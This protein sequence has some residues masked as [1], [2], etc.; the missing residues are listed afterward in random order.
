MLH[1]PTVGRGKHIAV[2]DLMSGNVGCA[3]MV[4]SGSHARV[5]AY[6]RST[7][8]LEDRDEAHARSRLAEEI[9]EATKAALTLAPGIRVSDV[10]AIV[11]GPWTSSCTFSGRTT[12]ES[13]TI[14]KETHISALAREA[15]KS[16]GAQSRDLLEARAISIRLNGYATRLPEG[17]RAREIE[18][19][20]LASTI[21]PA[22]KGVAASAISSALPAASLS[23]RSGM[24]AHAAM[25]P[26][27]TVLDALVI[28]VGVSVTTITV[29]KDGVPAGIRVITEGL[30][31]ILARAG[32][33]RPPQ[34]SL[35]RMRM[36]SRDA[37]ADDAS[38][39]LQTALSAA[40]PELVKIFGESFGSLAEL[41]RLP[42][43]VLLL[44]HPDASPY[45]IHFFER[46]DFSQFT[47][48]ASAFSVL[49][50]DNE[51]LRAWIDV[52]QAMDPQLAL[53]AS[54]A[55]LE[56]QST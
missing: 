17:K 24:A 23:W 2:V 10:F 20:A 44:A 31:S 56:A 22:L 50:L 15:L 39:A 30:A 36:L 9:G 45:L 33:T 1:V 35:S 52:P 34:E 14:I 25:V 8:M 40:E 13:E 32:D 29:F 5:L 16:A 42:S 37:H 43:R 46:I 53:A 48:T 27:L 49:P 28:D 26:R 51:A 54:Y 55:S 7:L 19:V 12:F 4:L 47:L 18:L 3:I 11:H 21:D 6:A 38:T 41:A